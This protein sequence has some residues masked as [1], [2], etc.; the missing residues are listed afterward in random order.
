M[1]VSIACVSN[2]Q[3]V[4]GLA[5][6]DMA[7]VWFCFSVHARIMKRLQRKERLAKLDRAVKN[8]DRAMR[9]VSKEQN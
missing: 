2:A 1:L 5:F 7:L 6:A 4:L 8:L 3:S 9:K